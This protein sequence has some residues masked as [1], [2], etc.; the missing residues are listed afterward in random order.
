MFCLDLTRAQWSTLC[1]FAEGALSV[2]L[3]ESLLV[4][5]SVNALFDKVR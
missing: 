1:L 3:K 2:D 5:H 4:K